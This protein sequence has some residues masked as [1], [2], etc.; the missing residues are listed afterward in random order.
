[1]DLQ[2]SYALTTPCLAHLTNI[3]ST[4]T[5]LSCLPF[6]L[7]L[8]TSTGFAS[9]LTT[10]S[11]TGNYSTLN[12]LLAYVTSPRPSSEA[13]DDYMRDAYWKMGEKHSACAPDL[14]KRSA[15]ADAMAG[16]GSAGLM[17]RAAGLRNPETGKWC[18]LEAVANDRPDDLYLWGLPAGIA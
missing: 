13:C 2:L 3:L 16:L 18:Y 14:K 12:T 5:F 8:T 15:A 7:L 4:P 1:M 11:N 17:R 9:L 10:A 6:S